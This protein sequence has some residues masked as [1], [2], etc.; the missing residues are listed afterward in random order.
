MLYRRLGRTGLRVSEIGLGCA[1]FWGKRIFNETDAIRLVHIAADHG[2]TFFD[3]GPSYSGG[4]AEPRLG[5]ALA[6][7][8]NKNDLVIATKAGTRLSAW[9]RAYKDWSPAAVRASVEESLRRLNLDAIALLQLHGPQ[10]SDL[11][12]GLLGTLGRLKEEGKIR[13]LSVNSFDM[14]VIAH[15]MTLPDF[16]AV[17]I[18]YNILRPER[19]AIMKD[20]AAREIGILAGG[21]LA[22]G[23]Y[24]KPFYGNGGIRDLWYAA[25]AWKNHRADLAR[26]RHFRFLNQE[27]GWTAGGIA[28]AW[29]L[30]NPHI[31]CAVFG[32]TRLPHLLA[33][34]SASG[35]TLEGS[36]LARIER[37]AAMPAQA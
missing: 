28:L 12:E 10:I 4:N 18:D 13:H 36:L 17:M 22:G 23:L 25:R 29:V 32:T 1:S 2:V 11:T 16:G 5:R 14:E 37:A 27:Q 19:A 9:G 30:A 7:L 24:S 15:V 6:G 31:G 35:R 8:K 34:L 21:A 3:T 26:S 33:A 20:L